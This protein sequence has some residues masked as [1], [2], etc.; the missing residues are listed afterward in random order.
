MPGIK[1]NEQ[2]EN[3]FHKLPK[4]IKKKAAKALKLLAQNYRH[5]SLQCKPVQGAPGVYE[6]RLDIHYRITF[7]RIP[8]DFLRL[9]RVGNHD[10]VLKNP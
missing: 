6:A 5:P 10:D 7:E 3:D 8:G 4:E 9:R 1:F 2:F